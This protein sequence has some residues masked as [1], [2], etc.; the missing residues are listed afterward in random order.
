MS[1]EEILDSVRRIVAHWVANTTPLA[2]DAAPGDTILEVVNTHRFNTGDEVAIYSQASGAETFLTVD[3][4]LDTT[5]LQLTSAINHPWTTAENAIVATT[6][7]GKFVQGIYLG[8][9]SVIP[10][11]PAITIHAISK[12]SEWMTLDSTRETYKLELNI[13]VDDSVQEDT[14]RFLLRVVDKIQRGLKNN[15]M[16]LVGPY[17]VSALTVDAVIGDIFLKVEDSS[18]FDPENEAGGRAV[19][20]DLFKAEE[21][22]IEEVVDATTIKIVTPLCFD[23]DVANSSKVISLRRFVYNSWPDNIQYGTIF[24][25]TMLKAAKISWFAFEEEI[26]LAAPLDTSIT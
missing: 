7:K 12:D 4:I 25:G 18:I 17:E 23:F 10:R 22:R 8:E 15:V 11:F 5:H 3:Q 20:E 21:F 6:F 1:V 19:M 24:K 16:P 2:A 9:P 13:Y 14:Y 26:H